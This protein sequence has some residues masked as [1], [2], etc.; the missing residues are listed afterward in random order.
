MS[1]W[2]GI[3]GPCSSLHTHSTCHQAASDKQIVCPFQCLYLEIPYTQQAVPTF[4]YIVITSNLYHI[5]D[6]ILPL[7]YL[8]LSS[9][10]TFLI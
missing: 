10:A 2:L 5:T 9:T 8:L 6:P 3:I 4:Q 7:N 1:S